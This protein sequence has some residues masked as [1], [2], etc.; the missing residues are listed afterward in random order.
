MIILSQPYKNEKDSINNFLQRLDE[1]DTVNQGMNFFDNNFDGTIWIHGSGGSPSFPGDVPPD[2]DSSSKDNPMILIP[3]SQDISNPLNVALMKMVML[4]EVVTIYVNEALFEGATQHKKANTATTQ[5]VCRC[6][7]VFFAHEFVGGRDS[8]EDVEERYCGDPVHKQKFA[9]YM[10]APYL[11]F[12]FKPLLSNTDLES[13]WDAERTQTVLL[14]ERKRKRTLQIPFNCKDHLETDIPIGGVDDAASLMPG[15]R[16]LRSTIIKRFIHSNQVQKYMIPSEQRSEVPDACG[17]SE[18]KDEVDNEGDNN[19]LL[20][21]TETY[22]EAVV[23]KMSA[24]IQGLVMAMTMCSVAGAYR[25][26]GSCFELVKGKKFARPL[27]EDCGLPDLFRIHPMPMPNR[28]LDVVSIGLRAELISDGTYLRCRT[29]P[30]CRIKFTKNNTRELVGT[31]F[32]TIILRFTGRLNSF[33]QYSRVA[34][35][36]SMLPAISDIKGFLA[37]VRSTLGGKGT[38]K[39]IPRWIS[40]QHSHSIP[41]ETKIYTGFEY[42]ISGI[43]ESL[44]EVADRM[45]EVTAVEF[46]RRKKALIL[47]RDLLLECSQTDENNKLDFM[48]HQVLSDVEEIFDEPFGKVTPH[49]VHGVEVVQNRAAR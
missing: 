41:K 49:S 33:W 40:E 42:F 43:A 47:L 2:A 5:E 44:G 11:K 1:K 36:D 26:T 21:A 17:T 27:L 24:D 18:S 13:I 4:R 20:D 45:L 6:L 48:A 30:D 31:L 28:A 38:V 15:K 7:G 12:A 35:R 23:K 39:R 9:R 46:T 25:Y 8:N 19:V 3:M 34:N 22:D 37:F 29:S 16:I 14:G 32:K 10:L